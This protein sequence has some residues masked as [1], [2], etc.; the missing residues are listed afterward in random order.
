MGDDWE[1]EAEDWEASASNF[2]PAVAAKPATTAKGPA[3][4]AE[5][6][7]SKFADEDQGEEPEPVVHTIKTQVSAG[8]GEWVCNWAGPWA[9]TECVPHGAGFCRPCIWPSTS[10]C[11][12]RSYQLSVSCPT[13]HPNTASVLLLSHS[14]A[15]I[16]P[17][18]HAH[19][20]VQPKKKEEKKWMKEEAQNPDDIP[21]DDPNAEKLRRQ[22]WATWGS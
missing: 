22:R 5:P 13:S 11:V 9:G 12:Y 17:H 21:L 14:H 6:D 3:A 16:P 18:T 20:R 7:L 19:T 15:C 2:K 1:D 10:C 4:G 8:E